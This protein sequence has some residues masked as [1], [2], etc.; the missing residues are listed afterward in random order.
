MARRYPRL[1]VTKTWVGW[2]VAV[3]LSPDAGPILQC[4]HA[5]HGAALRCAHGTIAFARIFPERW[6]SR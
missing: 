5:S 3:I 6:M 2:G 4:S 1:R